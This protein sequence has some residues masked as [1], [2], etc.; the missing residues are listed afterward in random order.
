MTL[1]LVSHDPGSVRSLCARAVVLDHG[2]AA[3]IGPSDEAT[4]VY[5]AISSGAQVGKGLAAAQP[6][7][8]RPWRRPP[9]ANGTALPSTEIGREGSASPERTLERAARAIPHGIE[10]FQDEIG[11]GTLTLKSAAR[12]STARAV[13]RRAYLAGESIR[14]GLSFVPRQDFAAAAVIAGFQLQRPLQ[15]RDRPPARRSTAA[16]NCRRCALFERYV[17]LLAVARSAS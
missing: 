16:S 11:D 4:S 10:R 13:R 5:H 3:F 17:L 6:A 7:E 14:I 8:A 15:Q 1:L 2:R 12:S 9:V